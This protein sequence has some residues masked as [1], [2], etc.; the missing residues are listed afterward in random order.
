MLKYEIDQAHTHLG[1]TAKHLAVSTVRGRACSNGVM[2]GI[3]VN[4]SVLITSYS[5]VRRSKSAS[6]N[7]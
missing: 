6:A 4:A 2:F 5:K 3:G 1:F 7:V